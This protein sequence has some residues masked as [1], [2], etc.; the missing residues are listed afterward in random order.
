M[1]VHAPRPD[2][3]P[4]RPGPVAAPADRNGRFAGTVVIAA[5]VLGA[6]HAAFVALPATAVRG[7]C[8]V[9]AEPSALRVLPERPAGERR[10]S[11]LYLRLQQQALRALA[12]RRAGFEQ[13]TTPADIAAWQQSRRQI[14][15]ETLGPLPERGDLRAQ[16]V[17]TLAGDGFRVEKV[18][19]AS[20]P[21]HHV[22]GNLYLPLT[23]GPHPAA[24]VPCGHSFNGKAADGYQR[25]SMLLA[26]NGVAALC[27]DPIGQGERYQTFGPDQQPLG[28]NYQGGASSV[29]QLKGI[30]GGPKFNPVEEHTLIGI[31]SILVGANTATYRIWDGMRAIDYLASRPDI[32]ARR[33]GC[34]GNSGGG[35]L[36]AYL[37]A[38]DDRIVAAAP[39][40]YLTSFERLLATAGPQDAEQNLFGQLARGL[41]E[42]D[43]VL[44]R[45]PKPT[46]LCAGTRDATF[47]ITG[48]WD[49]LRDA[50]RIYV[51]LGHAERVDI[52][53]A[54][55]PH[56][57]TKPLREAATRWL[58][59]WLRGRDEPIFEP[60]WKAFANAD[61]Q[62]TPRGQVMLLPDERSVF[63][64]NRDEAK[65]LAPRRAA[66]WAAATPAERIATVRRVAGIR[67]SARL[68]ATAEQ[69][70]TESLDGFQRRKIVL[71]R[72]DG[73][74]L[75]ALLYVPA[76][77]RPDAAAILYV[78]TRGKQTG[79]AANGVCETAARGGQLVL[80]V[81]P[82][83]LGENQVRH[84][85]DWGREL[86]GPNT[87]EFFLAY[88][89]EQSLVGL[90]TEDLLSAAT[91][92]AGHGE[93]SAPRTVSL[94]AHG[95]AAQL[96]ALHAR[97]V[98][99][100]RFAAAGP[101]AHN[102]LPRSW[103]ELLDSPAAG[104]RLPLAIHSVLAAY[105]LADLGR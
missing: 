5:A 45:A 23:P 56:G 69:V 84:P 89:L 60:E 17:G 11:T 86:F 77:P 102:D 19:F 61:L 41:D 81:D 87:Q 10:P 105:E 21:R 74:E 98:E 13:L 83:G 52:A 49:I 6:F 73:V 64:F 70:A 42:V 65:R 50:K 3:L 7:P 100:G 37:M 93:P 66:A 2:F 101:A 82:Q 51:R 96:A 8:A 68:A 91:Y 16:T 14:F 33:I 44:M 103:T 88:M 46:L 99:P 72:D 25:V 94:V 43:Y 55:E 59:R 62:C 90:H 38:L 12:H 47:D 54:D 78:D 36:T 29:A 22:T 40:C 53:E 9:A 79:A 30:P 57:F 39:T 35:T 104:D 67:D 18:I 75:P 28:G 34:T 20:R 48:T 85:R 24:I 27:Y 80:A 15:L 63:D 31:G 26:R 76:Q 95:P 58:V 71:K 1:T 92:L 32:D 4:P 97:F